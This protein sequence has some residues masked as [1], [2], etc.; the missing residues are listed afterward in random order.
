[1]TR[2]T[3]GYPKPETT[4]FLV[5]LTLGV[6]VLNVFL[7]T[8]S[9]YTLSGSR[10]EAEDSAANWTQNLALALERETAG[11]ISATDIALRAVIDE[12]ER[13]LTAGGIDGK[14][15]GAYIE[16]VHQRIPYSDG[17]RLSDAKGILR[18]GSGVVA[19]RQIDVSDRE[20]FKVLLDQQRDELVVS[21]PQK[22]RANGN[23]VIVFARRISGPDGAFAGMAF[24]PVPV[25]TLTKTFS[26][27]AIPANASITL[28]GFDLGVI[29]R[30]PAPL[31]GTEHVGQSTVGK[32]FIDLLAKGMA[33]GRFQAVTPLDGIARLLYFRKVGTYPLYLI[34]GRAEAEYLAEW[35][36]ERIRHG[37]TV[38]AFFFLTLTLWSLIFWYW[39]RL[40][41]ASDAME[42]MAKTDS[43]TELSSRREFIQEADLEIARAHRY[44][45]SLSA[46]ILDVDYFKAINDTHGHAVG[47]L[48]LKALAACIRQELREVDIVGRWGGEEFVALLPETD[49]SRARDA[50]ERLR[51]AVAAITV[52][53]GVDV[54]ITMTVSIGFSTLRQGDTD[55]GS[56]IRRADEALYRAK[57]G[58]RNRVCSEDQLQESG[59]ETAC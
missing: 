59:C 49:I 28:R 7:V 24:I 33:E 37:I 11:I 3:E 56:L 36:R 44:E 21:K 29:A 19:E 39:R 46:L 1:M 32:Q 31:G 38:V 12:A 17:V 23:W 27:M 53:A 9:A 15:L 13:Q 55:I 43:L 5:W 48:A 30:Y 2:P 52:P 16:R 58:G 25:A 26:R 10:D 8:Y 47:D 54:P 57:N 41:K 14:A 6:L 22:S 34:V 35:N 50:A 42:R 18:Y 40:A 45:N 4:G 51:A 20:H